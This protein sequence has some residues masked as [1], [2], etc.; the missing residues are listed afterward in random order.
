MQGAELH[1]GLVVQGGVVSVE[2]LRCQLLEVLLSRGAVDGQVD[3]E[4]ARQDAIDIAIH[5]GNRLVG[6]EAG[7]GGS[8]VGADARQTQEV[9]IGG[10]EGVVANGTCRFVQVTGA[11]VVTQSLP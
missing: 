8:G 1:D 4:E 7:N 3:V 5:H 11:A 2:Q 6:R 10:G 9:G